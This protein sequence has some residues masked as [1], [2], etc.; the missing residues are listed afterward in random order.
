LKVE[1]LERQ[2]GARSLRGTCLTIRG[3]KSCSPSR[4]SIRRRPYQRR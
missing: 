3:N 4:N 2:C 1:K